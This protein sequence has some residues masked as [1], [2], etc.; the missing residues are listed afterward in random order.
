MALQLK[1]CGMREADNIRRVAALGLDYMGF[2][3]YPKSP[4]FVGEAFQFPPTVPATMKRVGVF[5]NALTDV[6]LAAVKQTNLQA[7]QLHGKESAEQCRDLRAEGVEVIKVFSVDEHF[8]FASTKPYRDAVDYFLFDTKGKYLGGNGVTF[9]WSL[10]QRYD[11]EVPFFLSGGLGSQVL[12]GVH[13]LRDMNL[14]GLDVN[15]GVEIAPGVKD[16]NKIKDI[17]RILNELVK[18]FT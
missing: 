15:S 14:Y 18:S 4:R 6:M 9:D 13:Q 12:N 7:L 2:I 3:F 16:I 1:V 17:K 10:L 11:Q 5:V 8:D